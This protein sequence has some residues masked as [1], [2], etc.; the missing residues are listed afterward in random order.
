MTGPPHRHFHDELA[1]LKDRVLHM[2]SQVVE[3]LEQ[4]VA[5]LLDRDP[6]LAARVI[7]ADQEIDDLEIDIENRVTQLLA[8]QQ[9]MAKDLRLLLA[10]LKISNDLE[11]MGDHAVNIAECA[12]R[13][14]DAM[15][16]TP[17]PELVQ[18]TRL[19]R[20]MLSDVLSAFIKG[21][22]RAARD[23][24]LRDDQV[25]RL[26]ESMFRILLTHMAQ[27]H[28]MIGPSMEL[29]LVSR[30]LERV[31]DLATNIAEDV[32]FLV[33]GTTIKHHA[34]DKAERPV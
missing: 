9:P 19:A 20:D 23:V 16:I 33:E 32:V 24:C 34:E 13:L 15:P 30:N 22:T 28:R 14:I 25:D 26:H 31:G 8:L 29:S 2:S 7:A 18:M 11:R 10:C 21:D 4:A 3:V 17:P 12:V 5:S 1:L 6:E 27:D